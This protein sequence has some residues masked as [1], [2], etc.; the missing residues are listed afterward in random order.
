MAQYNVGAPMER[1]AADVL[2]PIPTSDSG[3]KYLLMDYFTKWTEAFP[4]PHQEAIKVAEVIVK[5][6][7]SRF[8]APLS[9]HSDQGCNFE[10]A[11]FSEMCSLLGIKKTRT[12]PLH[13]QSDGMVERFNRTLE[14]Q[15][16]KF[17]SNHQRDWDQ[18][19]PLL[20]MAY[21]TAVHDT[22]G[23]T[24]AKLMLGRDLRLPVDLLTG[25]PDN[26]PLSEATDYAIDLQE[27]LERVHDFARNNLKLKS[28]K[29]KEYYDASSQDETLN[30]GDPVWLYNPARKKGLSPKLM[31]PWQG[32]YIIVKKTSL[33]HSVRSEVQ[34]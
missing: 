30:E 14:A 2:G 21:R 12:T 16:S 32:P 20:M 10:S 33:P 13:P 27:K 17:V 4:L 9:L 8:G 28:D 31:R 6:V 24:P 11:A 29:M 5:E 23:N 1:I 26:E 15:L 3:N 7:V 18:H 34:A 19:V 22:S 25:R